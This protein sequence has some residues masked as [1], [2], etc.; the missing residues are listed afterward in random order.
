MNQNIRRSGFGVN[1]PP[2]NTVFVLPIF[3]SV[4]P[5]FFCSLSPSLYFPSFFFASFLFDGDYWRPGWIE[6]IWNKKKGSINK[7][8]KNIKIINNARRTKNK[9]FFVRKERKEQTEQTEMRNKNKMQYRRKDM[10]M[11][12]AMMVM[13]E[14]DFRF[15][16]MWLYPDVFQCPRGSVRADLGDHRIYILFCMS[17]ILYPVSYY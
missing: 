16:L 13:G 11:M 9:V 3:P 4:H 17:Y 8:I 6:E 2:Y 1:F 7:N 14:L 15:H 5:I 10:G 12:K